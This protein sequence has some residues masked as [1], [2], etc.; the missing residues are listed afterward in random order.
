MITAFHSNMKNTVRYDGAVSNAFPI[1]TRVKQGC[2]LTPTLFGIF[3]SLGLSHVFRTSE[4]GI[5]SHTGSDG[6]LFNLAR[7]KA[8]S[9]IRK[10]HHVVAN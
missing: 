4:D 9:K 1:K 2:V 5:Y 8:K 6:K 7:L 3:F 10:F